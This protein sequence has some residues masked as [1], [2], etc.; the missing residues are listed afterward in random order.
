MVDSAKIELSSLTELENRF[1]P[2]NGRSTRE[3]IYGV[4]ALALPS[5]TRKIGLHHLAFY[6]GYIQGI[7]IGELANRYLETGLDLRRAKSTLSW[8]RDTLK[9]AAL[10]HGNYRSARLL[11]MKVDPPYHCDTSTPVPTLAAFREEYDPDDFYTE[12]ELLEAFVEAHPAA[13]DVRAQKRHRLIQRQLEMLKWIEPLITTE[14]VK[15]DFVAAWFDDTIAKR[16]LLAGLPTLG[17]LMARI[18]ENGYRWWVSVPKLGEKGAARIV[19]WLGG[20]EPSLGQLPKHALVPARSLPACALMQERRSTTAIAPLEKFLVP[21]ELDGS[22]ASNR[23]SG[24]PRIKASNDYQA[25]K[26]WLD[27]KSGN[28]NTQRAYQKE[29]ERMLMWSILER[30]KALSNLSVEDCVA[31]RNWLSALGRT[32]QG[33]WPYRL[34]QAVW[35]GEKGVSRHDSEWRPFD[36]ALSVK[37]VQFAITITNS[38]FEWLVRVQYCIFNPWSGVSKKAIIKQ[39]AS[40]TAPEVEFTRAFTDGQWNYLMQYLGERPNTDV[41]TRLKFVLP[42]AQATG[43]RIS[44]LVDSTVGLIYTMP[45]TEGIGVRW[46]LKVLG[47]GGK[48]RAVPLPSDIVLAM[49]AYFEARGLNRNI[50]DNPPETPLIASLTEEATITTSALS[51]SVSGLFKE[52]AEALSGQGKAIEAKAFSGATVHWLRHT[53]GSHLAQSG[54]P[55]NV[56][57]RLLGHSNLQTTSIYTDTADETVWRAVEGRKNESSNNRMAY[58]A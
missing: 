48:W 17:D 50:I 16:L 45:L 22:T 15:A 1:N 10:R 44:E 21:S 42:F 26:S 51:K 9:Q 11:R 53:C 13:L 43:L 29:A 12:K 34:A 38:L 27:T 36:G 23:Y 14:P 4:E 32:E 18:I 25:I 6:R 40:E 56:I 37:S 8:L 20:Y 35:L 2:F 55:I 57:Q 7:D 41:S 3:E 19:A 28:Q 30:G 24:E 47:K 39:V 33:D 58:A 31:Y 54:V 49:Q 52:L 5:L 46:M